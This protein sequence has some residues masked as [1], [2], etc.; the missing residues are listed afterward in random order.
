ME[1]VSTG[2]T[3]VL[4]VED[5][6]KLRALLEEY[7]AK[8]GFQAVGVAD[9]ESAVRFVSERSFELVVL[10]VMIPGGDGFSV[11]R[12]IRD[13]FTGG[14]LMLTARRSEQDELTGLS[15]GADDYV[16]KPVK[17]EILIARARGILR[18]MGKGKEVQEPI[19]R[20]GS[21]IVSM[22]RRGAFGPDGNIGLT[23]SEFEL[24]RC[25]ASRPGVA[26]ER[27]VL[28]RLVRGTEHTAFDRAIDI[29][30]SR[31]RRKLERGGVGD[32]A[33]IA[34]RGTGYMMAMRDA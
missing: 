33:I 12:E 5:D 8:Q 21:L 4:L 24:V 34:V 3:R 27:D 10:D 19:R 7:F 13:R 11:L 20:L 26:V 18:R 1:A 15:L 9:G 29:H 14:I 22:E 31:V 16:T 25:L 32:V 17:P 30:V 23:Q 28:S 6:L 2:P